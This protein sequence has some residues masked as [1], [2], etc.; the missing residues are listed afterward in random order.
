MIKSVTRFPAAIHKTLLIASFLSPLL[1]SAQIEV[2]EEPK[3]L[4]YERTRRITNFWEM[5]DM[6]DVTHKDKLL[7][8]KNRISGNISYNTGRVV[9]DDGREKHDEWRSAIGYFL[10][11]RFFEQFSFNTTIYQD[12][13]KRASAHWTSNYSYGVGR[14]NWKPN[15]INFGYENYINN[16]F[17]DNRFQ[18]WDKFLQGYYFISYSD[19]WDKLVDKLKLDESTNIRLQYFA[20]YSVI[21]KDKYE[22][23]LRWKV[24]ARCRL[25]ICI[26]P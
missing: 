18:F 23:T 8:G 13:N 11:V 14:Y 16:R 21:Y 20:R 10:K 5:K 15:R 19:N 7:M 1:L 12:F 17:T 6:R 22:E 4:Y 25:Q 24:P 2:E 26:F 9:V 3:R